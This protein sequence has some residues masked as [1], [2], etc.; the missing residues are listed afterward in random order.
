MP[1]PLVQKILK[2]G[3]GSVPHF[4]AGVQILAV[5]AVLVL[6]K[7]YFQGAVTLSERKMHGKVIIVTVSIRGPRCSNSH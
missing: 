7:R 3:P 1:V 6:A 4:Y 5:V 2:D